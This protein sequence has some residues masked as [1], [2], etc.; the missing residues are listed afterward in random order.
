MAVEIHVLGRVDALVDGQPVQLRGRKERGVLAM[1]A[2]SANRTVSRAVDRRSL[3]RTPP[4]E[5]RQERPALLSRLRKVLDK[6]D[7]GASIITHGR[8]YELVLPDDAVDAARFEHLVERARREGE[9]GIAD[10][11]AKSALDLWRGAPL[12]DVAEEPFAAPEIRRLKSC[13][14]AR[15]S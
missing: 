6:D 14:C 12:A 4:G 13:I 3:A 11:A 8:G 2:L 10:G 7:S 9:R 5:R 15:S 1:L